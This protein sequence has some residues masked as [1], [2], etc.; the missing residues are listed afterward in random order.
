MK[1]NDL[2]ISVSP[3]IY[4]N[5][6]RKK[7]LKI[8]DKEVYFM[9]D[10]FIINS[11]LKDLILN[12]DK[13]KEKFLIALLHILYK[14]EKPNE[15]KE[16]T[17]DEYEAYKTYI[18]NNSDLK[19]S[20]SNTLKDILNNDVIDDVIKDYTELV[21][22]ESKSLIDTL[23]RLL[24]LQQK[25]KGDDIGKEIDA[26]IKEWLDYIRAYDKDKINE[27]IDPHNKKIGT[28]E[29]KDA[30]NIMS[31]WVLCN[32]I[33]TSNFI[34]GTSKRD[35]AFMSKWNYKDFTMTEIKEFMTNSINNNLHDSETAK[36]YSDMINLFI[37]GIESN[38]NMA[39][40]ERD[41]EQEIKAIKDKYH[42]IDNVK[43]GEYIDPYLEEL[44]QLYYKYEQ[45]NGYNIQDNDDVEKW[46]A[47]TDN[48]INTLLNKT[49]KA[50]IYAVNMDYTL[51]NL[52]YSEYQKHAYKLNKDLEDNKQPRLSAKELKEKYKDMTL[53]NGEQLDYSRK[54]ARI[55]TSK[56]NNNIYDLRERITQKTQSRT[57]LTQD[58][59]NKIKSKVKPTKEDLKQLEELKERLKE[60]E[61][62]KKIL[63]DEYNDLSADLDLIDKQISDT[64]DAKEIKS[65]TSKRKK[66][67]KILN[68][69]KAILENEGIH[70]QQQLF[71]DKVLI[72]EKTNPKTKESYKLMISNDYDIQNFNQE[73][74]NFLYYIPNIPNIIEELNEDFI[75]L[76]IKDYLDFTGRDKGNVSRIRTNLQNTLKEMR[77]ETYDYTYLDDKGVLHDDSLV[78]IGDIK[79][80][81]H[82]GKA[83]IKVQ[84]GATFKDNLKQAFIKGQIGRVKSDVFKLGQGKNNKA[85]NM[86]KEIFLYLAKLCRIEAK[87]QVNGG[88][89]EKALHL[90]TIIRKLAE[91][92]LIKYNPNRYNESVKE[93]LLYALNTGMELGYFT[94]ETD[95]FKYY[96]DIIASSNNGANVKDKIDNFENGDKYG[97]KFI[98]NGDVI[99][100]ETNTKANKKYRRYKNKATKK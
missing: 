15:H 81:E 10:N 22:C 91:L 14:N 76:D 74:R 46:H 89:Y 98:I 100:L 56:V 99:D 84:L 65:L 62:A 55:D 30:L 21:E 54:W 47:K 38:I 86:A 60:Q 45:D 37:N 31:A 58:K 3:I 11:E 32:H 49:D 82:N 73:G 92:N 93:P 24:C 57:D 64:T 20:L 16:Y 61:Q 51:D 42:I 70:I 33:N 35:K 69:K 18:N 8:N 23:S 43:G 50:N 17:L 6:N 27:I 36:K 12:D 34:L 29:Y 75:T 53:L 78:L 94:Y 25:H 68:D 63:L 77:K 1:N 88:K 5:G 95:A 66:I 48:F 39:N 71:S 28:D 19:T 44:S 4:N 13:L 2:K 85:E 59:I 67:Q 80:T 41:K 90:D 97:I 26:K 40:F 52:A 7:A 87:N 72:A 79:G 83:T 9:L 96:D